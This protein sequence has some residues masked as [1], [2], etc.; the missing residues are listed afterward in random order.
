MDRIST[1]VALT[2]RNIFTEDIRCVLCEEGEET[3]DHVFSG[4]GFSTGV[5]DIVSK[6]CGIPNYFT[7]SLKDVMELHNVQGISTTHKEIVRGVI[8]A[9]CWRLWKARNEF[10]FENKVLK[11]VEIVADIKA[12][13]YLWYS[14]S[15]N[16]EGL[17]SENRYKL[18]LM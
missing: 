14:N 10:I 11:V 17:D 8:I 16:S 7:F 2:K 9:S 4:C 15:N 1:K 5:W 12:L 13:T 6:W 18:Y 3:V